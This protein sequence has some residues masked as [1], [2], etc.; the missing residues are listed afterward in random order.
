MECVFLFFAAVLCMQRLIGTVSTGS[1][2]FF[3]L[4]TACLASWVTGVVFG[5]VP[6][7]YDW[8]RYTVFLD[9]C[10]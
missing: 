5:T 10:N 9:A 6:V 1:P 4:V 3:V 8:I 2:R 7:V